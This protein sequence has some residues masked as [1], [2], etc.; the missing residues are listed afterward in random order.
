MLF[1][2]DV[3][4]IPYDVQIVHVHVHDVPVSGY[5]HDDVHLHEFSDETLSGGGLVQ[6]L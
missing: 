4:Q 5:V 1:I 2:Y 3:S 6:K